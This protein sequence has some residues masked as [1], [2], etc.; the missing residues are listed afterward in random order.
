MNLKNLILS[1]PHQTQRMNHLFFYLYKVLVREKLIYSERNQ[2][3]V[4]LIGLERMW[5]TIKRQE[6]SSWSDGNVLYLSWPDSYTGIYVSEILKL[7]IKILAFYGHKLY[8]S[9]ANFKKKKRDSHKYYLICWYGDHRPIKFSK[10]EIMKIFL[11]N[12]HLFLR[13]SFRI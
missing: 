3:R 9:K 6:K 13:G 5:L 11:Q 2:I 12:T 10:L 1:E 7:C 4:C 8:S